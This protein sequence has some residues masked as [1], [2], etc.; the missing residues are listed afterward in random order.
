MTP[1]PLIIPLAILIGYLVP[2]GILIRKRGVRASD[3]NL[4]LAGMGISLIWVLSITPAGLGQI[5]PG[6]Q[7]QVLESFFFLALS[8]VL[9]EFTRAFLQQSQP[10]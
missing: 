3:T 10:S 5:L 4:L 7:W 1:S 6:I 2:A 9:L 8:V